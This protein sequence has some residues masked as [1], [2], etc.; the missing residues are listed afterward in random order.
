[1]TAD[2][3]C[4]FFT[5]SKP[6]V[7]HKRDNNLDPLLNLEPIMTLL[8]N[9]V[10]LSIRNFPRR[11]GTERNC[12]RRRVYGAHEDHLNLYPHFPHSA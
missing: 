7:D 8:M 6:E 9:T 5:I 4:L 1:M 2:P 3:S 12:R 11:R 10:P